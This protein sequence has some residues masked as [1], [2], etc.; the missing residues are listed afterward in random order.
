MSLKDTK[1]IPINY[2]H[3]EFRTIRED[4]LDIASRFYPDNFQDWSEASF[5]SLMID[6]VAYVGDQLSLYLDYNI[7]ESFLDTSFSRANILRHGKILGYKNSG[8]PSTYG[9]VALF[10]EVPAETSGLGPDNSKIPILKKGARFISQNGLN[11][12]L[13]ENVDFADPKYPVVVASVDPGTGAPTHYAIKA[14]GNVVSGRYGTAKVKAGAFKKFK[15]IKTPVVNLAEIISVTDSEGREYFEVDYLAQDV[16][17]RE[18]PNT[19]YKNDNVPSILKPYLVS[20][21]FTVFHDGV[22]SYLQFGSGDEG[23]TSVIARPQEVA[24]NTFA[25]SYVSTTT[26]DPTR[27][28][29]NTEYGIVPAET[30]LTIVYRTT[31]PRNSNVATGQLNKVGF[32]TFDF[33]SLGDVSDAVTNRVKSSLEVSNE[34]PIVGAISVP[35]TAELKQRVY[36]TFPT[37]DRAVTQADYESLAYRMHSKFGNIKRVSIQK[38]PDSLKRNLNLYVISESPQGKLIKSNATIKNN[39]KTWLSHYRMINDTIDIL[40]AY[41]INLGIEFS[42][43]V[44]ATADRNKVMAEC[45]MRLQNEFAEGFF[46]GEHFIISNIYAALK[47]VQDVLDVVNVNIINKTGNQYSNIIYSINHN[48]SPHGNQL[49]CPKN[50]IFEIKFPAVD[51]KGK[52]R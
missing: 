4:L 15:R 28:S 29:A 18:I 40:D 21:K 33:G 12:A 20:R 37:Q 36:D 16:V 43:D 23:A 19:N 27:L 8:T 22:D 35:G 44:P 52:V 3:R 10:L 9:T 45:L 2:T 42:V 13:I 11:F 26:F 25:K 46:I 38:D 31:N 34:S 49:M 6:A 7:N 50:A 1:I 39:L 41:I 24:M 17:Y 14:Y 5:G 51:I 47:S 32:A 48:L 30:D